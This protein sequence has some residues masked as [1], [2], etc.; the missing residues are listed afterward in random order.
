V[1]L[2]IHVDQE[3]SV[4]QEY[5][6][7]PP[8]CRPEELAPPH[9]KGGHASQLKTGFRAVR[10][11]RLA[12]AIR[13]H[14]RHAQAPESSDQSLARQAKTLGNRQPTPKTVQRKA[15]AVRQFPIMEDGA[16]ARGAPDD[17]YAR[18]AAHLCGDNPLRTLQ[19]SQ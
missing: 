5:R 11:P 6:I 19:A 12:R 1:H 15:Q 18:P 10:G 14:G 4:L 2:D 3:R 8:L 13:H 16:P 7:P 9:Q 17:G